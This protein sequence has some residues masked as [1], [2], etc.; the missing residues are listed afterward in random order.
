MHELNNS[1]IIL[2]L[3]MSCVSNQQILQI[4]SSPFH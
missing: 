4:P 1:L 3:H 2:C